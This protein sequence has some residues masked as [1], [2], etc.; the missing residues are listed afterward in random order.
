MPD[1]ISTAQP[2]IRPGA[3][4]ALLAQR[5]GDKGIG[6]A[7]VRLAG[8]AGDQDLAE[9]AS[10]ESVVRLLPS[11]KPLLWHNLSEAVLQSGAPLAEAGH[12]TRPLTIDDVVIRDNESEALLAAS[13]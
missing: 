9:H 10:A 12:A 7:I 4:P 11:L 1:I 5:T 13:R 6:P 3:A 2:A 8:A